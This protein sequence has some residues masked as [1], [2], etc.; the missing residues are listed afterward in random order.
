MLVKKFTRGSNLGP[1]EIEF[2][3]K[4]QYFLGMNKHLIDAPGR[5]EAA[6]DWVRVRQIWRRPGEVA[7][8]QTAH[9]ALDQFINIPQLPPTAEKMPNQK[10]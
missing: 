1:G 7:A 4:S 8:A 2:G 6:Q 10:P 3:V 9:F 5:L